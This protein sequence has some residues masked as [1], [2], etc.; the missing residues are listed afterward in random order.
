MYHTTF[1]QKTNTQNVK[2]HKT[3]N[4]YKAMH[5]L[6]YLTERMGLFS[7]RSLTKKTKQKQM[8]NWGLSIPIFHL[9][10]T[11]FNIQKN[12]N[13]L[14]QWEPTFLDHVSQISLPPS[15][16]ATLI[17]FPS[18][19]CCAAFCSQPY[20]SPSTPCNLFWCPPPCTLCPTTWA[21]PAP[22]R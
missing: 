15:P 1:T 9:L 12:Q 17:L 20:T 3:Q 10:G 4:P 5:L 14:Q 16:S 18:L 8:S 11:A 6:Q 19:I 2:P 13:F 21:T 7:I 22:A